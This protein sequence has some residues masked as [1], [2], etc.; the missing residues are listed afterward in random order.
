MMNLSIIT[1]AIPS[2]GRLVIELQPSVHA[3][4][5]HED[6]VD[7]WSAS[8]KRNASSVRK[9]FNRDFPVEPLSPGMSV[10][11]TTGWRESLKDDTE[12]TEGLVNQPNVIQQTIHFE[13]H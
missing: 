2:L 1:T 6:P 13:V 10:Q 12:S 8:N 9:S 3:F 7:G 5:I 11:V 4:T